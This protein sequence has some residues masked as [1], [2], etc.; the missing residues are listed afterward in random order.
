MYVWRAVKRRD[1]D[2]IIRE[3]KPG[4][5]DPVALRADLNEYL[6]HYAGKGPH[7]SQEEIEDLVSSVMEE[8]RKDL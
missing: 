6:H 2:R 8:H 4:K 1:L 3:R 7:R 5:P